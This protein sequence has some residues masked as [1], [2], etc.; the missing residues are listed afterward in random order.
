MRASSRWRGGCAPPACR[1]QALALTGEAAHTD[2]ACALSP[3][4]DAVVALAGDE[5]Q[6]PA[7][8]VVYREFGGA[9]E[10]RS[11]APDIADA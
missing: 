7:P 9:P 8:A 6:A 4:H 11:R 2:P 1:C 3:F 10:A 5:A